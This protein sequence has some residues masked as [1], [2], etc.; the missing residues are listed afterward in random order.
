MTAM[1]SSFATRL[2]T[3]ERALGSLEKRELAPLCVSDLDGEAL[4]AEIA[5]WRNGEDVPGY[6]TT[7][8]DRKTAH[9]FVLVRLR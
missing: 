4:D 3:V 9:L 1:K 2:A 8:R 7:V 6:P 5:R